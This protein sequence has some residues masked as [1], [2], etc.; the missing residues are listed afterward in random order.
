MI[1]ISPEHEALLHA[2]LAQGIRSK[3]SGVD[4]YALWRKGSGLSLPV[5]GDDPE[6]LPTG[7]RAFK[8]K[9]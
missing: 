2:G 3:W 9:K 4:E 5:A 8:A 1:A 7:M 6:G